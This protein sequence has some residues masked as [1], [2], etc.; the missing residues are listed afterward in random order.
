MSETGSEFGREQPQATAAKSPMHRSVGAGSG[1]IL[2]ATYFA[3]AALVSFFL[4]PFL[5]RRSGDASFGLLSVTWELGGYF[6]LLDLGL[7]SAVNYHVARSAAAG[8]GS[9]AA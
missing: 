5:L 8:A 1:A 9:C 2:N 6:G 7:R 4:S 3:V